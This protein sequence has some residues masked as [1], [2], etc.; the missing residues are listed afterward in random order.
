MF[1]TKIEPRISET[2][3]AGHINN[4]TIPIW[5]EAG[6][7]GIFKLFTPSSLFKDWKLVIVNMNVDFV[8]EIYYG[9]EVII[10]TWIDRLGNSS[11]TIKEEIYQ[12]EVLCAK[13]TSAYV[14]YNFQQKKSE[15]ISESI[16]EQLKG[17]MESL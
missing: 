15:P 12:D 1:I 10:K 14:N 11:F 7:I 17:H 13:G 3:G 5:F 8:H 9:R 4:T 6:R 16:R 2:D